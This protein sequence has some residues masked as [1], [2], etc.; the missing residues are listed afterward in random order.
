MNI[1][2]YKYGQYRK[3]ASELKV[4]FMPI[5]SELLKKV[6]SV[7]LEKCIFFPQWGANYPLVKNIVE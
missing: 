6:A 1:V 2:R 4:E 3:I 5:Y 7:K